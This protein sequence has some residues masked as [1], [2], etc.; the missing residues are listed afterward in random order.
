MEELFGN[1]NLNLNSQVS[2]PSFH[3][4]MRHVTCFLKKELFHVFR[5]GFCCDGFSTEN[6]TP[7]CNNGIGGLHEGN[8]GLQL[9]SKELD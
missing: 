4:R 6:T 7:R 5:P 9:L 2:R 1:T 3:T 8:S